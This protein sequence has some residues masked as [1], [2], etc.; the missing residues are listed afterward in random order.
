LP[1]DR[2]RCKICK[3]PE[4]ATCIELSKFFFG[5]TI[6]EIIHVYGDEIENLNS[7]NVSNHLDKHANPEERELL[8]NARKTMTEEEKNKLYR[9]ASENMQ[10][11]YSDIL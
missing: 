8:E 10:R 6:N 9:Q 11:K 2:F 1:L 7:Y 4:V 5:W 3:K